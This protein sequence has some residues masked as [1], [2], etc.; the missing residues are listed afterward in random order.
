MNKYVFGLLVVITTALMGSSFAIGKIA[1]TYISPL[2]LNAI[3]FIIAGT[4]I[5]GV[6]I[7]I[8]KPHPRSVKDWCIIGL[9]GLFQTTAVMSFIF[10]SLNTI[11]ASQSSILTF[12]NPLLVIVF[13]TFFLKTRYQLRHWCGVIL[14]FIGVFITLDGQLDFQTGTLLSLLA[15]VSWAIA[16]ILIK[17]F[18]K[19][20]DLWVLTGYQML[21]GGLFL[22]LFSF[23]F[24]EQT[25]ILTPAS[26]SLTLWLAIMASVVQFTI[27]FYLL[28]KGDPG[29]TSAFL[30]LAPFFG[31]FF[32]WLLLE[33]ILYV[34][35]LIGGSFILLGIFL[36]NW[37]GKQN[38]VQAEHKAAK[39]I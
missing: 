30:F 19:R 5:A 2:L 14:G 16:T 28:Q 39:I 24:E 25:L 32:G 13:S 1:L 31:V 9:I 22:L 20:F 37:N 36:V 15:A 34:T 8:K 4:I 17:V 21:F 27:W 26:I 3:R 23:L 38:A 7:Y 35:T 10:M 33:E 12:I 18:G 11:P 29:K 6:I